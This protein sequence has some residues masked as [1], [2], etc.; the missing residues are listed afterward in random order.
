LSTRFVTE[1]AAAA[2]ANRTASVA[3]MPSLRRTASAP[4]N[5]SPLPWRRQPSPEIR[6]TP[7]FLPDAAV[8][9]PL[10]EGDDHDAHTPV[11][12]TFGSPAADMSSSILMPVRISASDSLGVNMEILPQQIGRATAGPASD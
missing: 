6:A 2:C 1:S 12:E 7:A 4:L 3:P 10:A 11:E 8:G 9:A 5:T